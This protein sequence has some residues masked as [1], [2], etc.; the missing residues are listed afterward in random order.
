MKPRSRRAKQQEASLLSEE[1][2][3]I[4]PDAAAIEP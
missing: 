2:Q 3:L 4:E 1:L